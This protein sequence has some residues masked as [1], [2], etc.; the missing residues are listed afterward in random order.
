MPGGD[1]FYVGRPTTTK[2]TGTFVVVWDL[3][4]Q[5]IPAFVSICNS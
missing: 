2:G 1:F 4:G 3:T 5:P